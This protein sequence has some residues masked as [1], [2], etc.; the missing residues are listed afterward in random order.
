MR[1]YGLSRFSDMETDY[2]TTNLHDKTQGKKRNR[3][4]QKK[5]SIDFDLMLCM[6]LT[7]KEIWQTRR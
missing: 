1:K 6:N 3:W 2:S 5:R 4:Q 7:S